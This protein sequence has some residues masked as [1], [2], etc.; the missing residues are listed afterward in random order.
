MDISRSIGVNVKAGVRPGFGPMNAWS[1]MRAFPPGD[2]KEVVRPNFD[3]LYSIAWL[4]LTQEPVIISAPDTQ[5][6]YYLLPI[7]DMWTDV[8]AAPGKRTSGTK[9]ISFAVTG[10]H[11]TGALPKGVTRIPSTTS[12]VWIIGRTQT[13]GPKD[14]EAVH[15][16]QDGYKLTRLN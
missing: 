4:D 10:P 13:N 9:P 6:K 2:F 14:Y 15:K 3:T 8:L 12:Y 11:W 7:M 5:G 1:H 16:V